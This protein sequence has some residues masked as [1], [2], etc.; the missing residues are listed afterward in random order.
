MSIS[1]WKDFKKDNAIL[2]ETRVKIVSMNPRRGFKE[3]EREINNCLG[4]EQADDVVIIKDPGDKETW[5]HLIIKYTRYQQYTMND[6]DDEYEPTGIFHTKDM[7]EAYR[8]QEN[9][10]D[11]D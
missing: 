11:E 5:P 8:A 3:V 6:D 7:Y 9:V 1:N 10:C 2:K 4:T